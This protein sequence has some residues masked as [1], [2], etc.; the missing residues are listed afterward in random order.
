MSESV[1]ATSFEKSQISAPHPAFRLATR[2]VIVGR[3]SLMSK[4]RESFVT[5]KSNLS[6]IARKRRHIFTENVKIFNKVVVLKEHTRNLAT[7]GNVYPHITLPTHTPDPVEINLV[8]LQHM[9]TMGLYGNAIIHA[10]TAQSEPGD[11]RKQH[12]IGGKGS[13]TS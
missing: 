13:R 10:V 5:G 3:Q 4:G 1:D 9:P 12:A 8:T 6:Q 2:L 11:L 7:L